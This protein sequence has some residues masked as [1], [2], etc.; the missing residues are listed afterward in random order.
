MSA[1]G[2]LIYAY[3][4]SA[5]QANTPLRGAGSVNVFL[6]SYTGTGAVAFGAGTFSLQVRRYDPDGSHGNWVT[7]KA[8]A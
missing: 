4:D 2:S 8:V 5:E 3:A 1:P 7:L 6:E